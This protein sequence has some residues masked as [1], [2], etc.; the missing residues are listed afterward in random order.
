MTGAGFDRKCV[1]VFDDEE[2]PTTYVDNTTLTCSPPMAASADAVDVEV[3]RGED[4]SDVLLFE[5]VSS[6]TARTAKTPERKPKKAEPVHKRA[7][8]GKK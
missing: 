3:H 6:T 8:K 4:M 5:F 2:M 1:V 7:K